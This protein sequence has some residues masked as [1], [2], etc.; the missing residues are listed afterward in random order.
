[1]GIYASM[2]CEYNDEETTSTL[3]ANT[4]HTGDLSC[5]M[6]DTFFSENIIS[7]NDNRNTVDKEHTTHT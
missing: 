1:M 7:I 3:K 5:V 2:N 4:E 6:S